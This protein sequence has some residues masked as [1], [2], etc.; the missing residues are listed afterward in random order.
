MDQE[1]YLDLAEEGL[2]FSSSSVELLEK[3]SQDLQTATVS[4]LTI[5]HLL[6]SEERK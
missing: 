2:A 6:L 5:K 1:L 4:D 3:C